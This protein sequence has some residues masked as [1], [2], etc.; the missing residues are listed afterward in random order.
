[1]SSRKYLEKHAELIQQAINRMSSMSLNI[2]GLLVTLITAGYI[3]INYCYCI[4]FEI[5]TILLLICFAVLDTLYLQYERKFRELYKIIIEDETQEKV[6]D[7]EMNINNKYV[8]AN[9]ETKYFKCLLSKSILIPY[10]AI[11]T[12]DLILFLSLM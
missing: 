8:K 2:K 7:L 4:L 5:A 3:F 1:M 11:L 6:K 10:F 9:V 12:Y